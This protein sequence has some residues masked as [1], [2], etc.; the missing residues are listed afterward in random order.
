M[1]WLWIML[2]IHSIALAEGAHQLLSDFCSYPNLSFNIKSYLFST[3]L[4]DIFWMCLVDKMTKLDCCLL[5]IADRGIW[6]IYLIVKVSGGVTSS[7]CLCPQKDNFY[8][9]TLSV[10]LLTHTQSH[11]I[12]FLTFACSLQCLQS[13]YST[14][15]IRCSQLKCGIQYKRRYLIRKLLSN[16]I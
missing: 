8:V 2:S 9:Y 15:L 16:A 11:L 10:H 7:Y 14:S 12:L 13:D 3:L 6:E 5:K 4:S 1:I